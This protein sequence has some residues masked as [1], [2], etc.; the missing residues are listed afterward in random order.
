MPDEVFALLDEER[1]R[2]WHAGVFNA[3]SPADRAIESGGR[4]DRDSS[5]WCVCTKRFARY[6]HRSLA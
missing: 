5:S 3:E 4:G 1:V 6:S 2:E